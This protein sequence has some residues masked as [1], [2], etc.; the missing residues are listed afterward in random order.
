MELTVLSD[1]NT[2]TDRYFLGEPGLSFHIREGG[3][4]VLFDCGYSDVF[5]RNAGRAGIDLGA[6]DTVAL[7]HG[8]LDHTWGLAALLACWAGRAAEGRPVPRPVLVAHPEALAPRFCD[9]APIGALLGEAALADF[10]DVRL[11]REP[12]WLSRRLVFLGEIPRRLPFEAG[13]P[14]GERRVAGG[15]VPDDVPD[16]SALAYLGD[17][18]L[19]IVTGCS[20][21]G[22][23]N[24]VAH[25]REVTGEGRLAAVVGGLHLLDPGPGRLEATVDFLRA[26]GPAALYPCH[27]TGLAARMALTRAAPVVEV[28]AGLVLAFDA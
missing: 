13:P 21:A 17:G 26:A 18:G 4:R 9:G 25:A 19:V 7:S 5:C 6:L 20:H 22:I 2:L 16:D 23:C 14:I 12:L 3:R 11:T 10:F 24:I 15:T 8:H 27:C 1:N 28:G